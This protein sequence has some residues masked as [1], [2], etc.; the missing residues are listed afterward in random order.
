MEKVGQLRS[1]IQK[2]FEERVIVGRGIAQRR[3]PYKVKS[4]LA[5]DLAECLMLFT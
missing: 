2:I 5:F 1:R 4:I 3:I